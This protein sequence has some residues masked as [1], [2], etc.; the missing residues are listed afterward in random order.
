MHCE[1]EQQWEWLHGEGASCVTRR[2]VKLSGFLPGQLHPFGS[3]AAATMRLLTGA[4]DAWIPLPGERGAQMANG[5]E[6]D[7]HA[8]VWLLA[9]AGNKCSFRFTAR[10]SPVMHQWQ[11][12]IAVCSSSNV[13]TSSRSNLVVLSKNLSLHFNGVNWWCRFQH[14]VFLLTSPISL[15]CGWNAGMYF[16][17]CTTNKLFRSLL[18]KKYLC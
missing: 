12:M 10:L 17:F 18:T 1:T 5:E 15:P 13:K 11:M 16:L 6:S 14:T 9:W 4:T 8:K 7:A 2:E 3:L